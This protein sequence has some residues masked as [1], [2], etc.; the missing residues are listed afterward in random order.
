MALL[1]QC[2]DV[3]NI[4]T[5]IDHDVSSLFSV[6]W[7]DDPWPEILAYLSHYRLQSSHAAN[8]CLTITVEVL[9]KVSDKLTPCFF[10]AARLS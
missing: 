7:L 4:D 10:A 2:R 9:S 5:K 1:S 8:H 3:V 6:G